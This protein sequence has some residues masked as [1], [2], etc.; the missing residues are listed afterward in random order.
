MFT[1]DLKASGYFQITKA[2]VRK[3]LLNFTGTHLRTYVYFYNI[4][5]FWDRI[6]T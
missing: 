4:L 2:I 6:K 5:G 1:I 3:K